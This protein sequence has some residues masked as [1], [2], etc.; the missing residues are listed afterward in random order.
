MN[1]K[2]YLVIAI[3]V[4]S[5]QS[6]AGHESGGGGGVLYG[7]SK[8][9]LVD[10]LNINPDFEDKDSHLE[11]NSSQINDV[12][13][14]IELTRIIEDQVRSE[15]SAFDLALTIIEKWETQFLDFTAGT[16]HTAF[17]KPL[18]WSFTEK[19]LS[20]PDSYLP[21]PTISRNNIKTAAYYEKDGRNYSVI[22]SRKIWNDLGVLSQ[23]GLLVHEVLRHQ[24]IGWS[25]QFDE[26][27]LQQA[28]ALIMLC[29]PHSSINQYLFYVT[30]NRSDLA[31]Y[32]VGNFDEVIKKYCK[33]VL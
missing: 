5:V 25:N 1:K 9:V 11:W 4:S 32:L 18:T 17:M 8:P 12:N 13:T 20:A 14:K 23:A 15:N 7:K 28:T 10:F 27:S 3:L 2:I 22:I 31:Q 6:F 30:Q 21:I 24:Q 19:N 33:R 26:K 29:E 16:I